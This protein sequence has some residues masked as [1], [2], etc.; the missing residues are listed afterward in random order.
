M[1]SVVE[2]G[3][4]VKFSDDRC[5]LLNPG[6]LGAYLKFRHRSTSFAILPPMK[7]SDR[8]Q[9]S[10]HCTSHID[11]RRVHPK[12]MHVIKANAIAT[13]HKIEITG[14]RQNDAPQTWYVNDVAYALDHV[15]STKVAR[16]IEEVAPGGNGIEFKNDWEVKNGTKGE[17]PEARFNDHT[18]R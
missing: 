15:D 14:G 8:Q 18:V 11:V 9:K 1:A 16:M 13:D 12:G 5:L 3:V 10:L 2:S 17:C 4:H 7:L 6:E